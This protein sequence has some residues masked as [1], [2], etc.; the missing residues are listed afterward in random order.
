MT[1][2]AETVSTSPDPASSAGENRFSRWDCALVLALGLGLTLF[3]WFDTRAYLRTRFKPPISFAFNAVPGG[4]LVGP[5]SEAFCHADTDFVQLENFAG[6]EESES[7]PAHHIRHGLG[8][9]ST[10]TIFSPHAHAHLGL[11]FDSDIEDQDLTV[12]CNGEVLERFAHLA[13]RTITRSYPLTL[14]PG[15][16]RVTFSYGRYNH[17]GVH[18]LSADPR[19]YA[20]TF[21]SLDLFLE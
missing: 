18:E 8:P 10:L 9:V 1:H 2:P 13:Q 11:R 3:G 21:T 20:G 15:A 19:P 17:D 12:A 7:A 6:L 4:M 16:N 5:Q 14:H